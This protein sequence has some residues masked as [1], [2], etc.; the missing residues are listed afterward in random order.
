MRVVEVRKKPPAISGE[1]HL[2]SRPKLAVVAA[3]LTTYENGLFQIVLFQRPYLMGRP[4][5]N[6]AGSFESLMK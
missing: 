6:T 4:Q 3:P 5:E 1:A 2:E